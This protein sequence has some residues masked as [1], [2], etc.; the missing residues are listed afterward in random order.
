LGLKFSACSVEIDETPL[1]LERPAA[2]VTRIARA[3]A[4][5]V[6]NFP[7]GAVII[8]VDT[9]IGIGK[10]IIG[11][12]RDKRHAREILAQ[13]SGRTHEVLSTI[14]I[15]DTSSGMIRLETTRT[16]VDFI[17]LNDTAI[18]WYLS[19]GEWKNRAGAYAIQANGA[20]LVK[21]VRGCL[22]NVIGIS[23]PSLISMLRSVVS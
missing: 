12:P 7:E 2:Y 19:T 23:I 13:L 15:H 17:T 1:P 11:K 22:T 18:D 9:T 20:S 21:E 3:K 14:A 5:A 10:D 8:A 6:K 4:G 16:E